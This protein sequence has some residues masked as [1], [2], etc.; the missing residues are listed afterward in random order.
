MPLARTLLS[1]SLCAKS[2]SF[3][4]SCERSHVTAY[5]DN[6]ASGDGKARFF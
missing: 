4:A 3:T 1:S 6:G 5:K 2:D